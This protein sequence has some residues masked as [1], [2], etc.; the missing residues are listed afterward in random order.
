MFLLVVGQ[1]IPESQPRE[2]C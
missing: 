1:Q 2:I